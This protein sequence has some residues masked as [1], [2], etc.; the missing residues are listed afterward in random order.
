MHMH[1]GSGLFYK[2]IYDF[3]WVDA[4]TCMLLIA[5]LEF[6]KNDCSINRF[7]SVTR[8]YNSQPFCN[9][10]PIMLTMRLM[11]SSTYYAK[12]YAAWAYPH[13]AQ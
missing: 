7:Y 13:L 1:L 5:L 8:K 3:N 2:Q 10:L 11:L 12:N 9:Y 6:N 4:S